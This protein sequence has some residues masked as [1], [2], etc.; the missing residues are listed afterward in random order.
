MKYESVF[1]KDKNIPYVNNRASFY[2]E[3]PNQIRY[4]DQVLKTDSNL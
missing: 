3:D 4:P 2:R 1:E